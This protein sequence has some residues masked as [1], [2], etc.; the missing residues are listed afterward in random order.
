M[1]VAVLKYKWFWYWFITFSFPIISRHCLSFNKSEKEDFRKMHVFSSWF[2]PNIKNVFIISRHSD[3]H[4][5]CNVDTILGAFAVHKFS[6][7]V[8]GTF[9]CNWTRRNALLIRQLSTTSFKRV[10]YIKGCRRSRPVTVQLMAIHSR[11]FFLTSSFLLSHFFPLYFHPF[12][13]SF[14]LL[15]T[16]SF[17]FTFRSVLSLL[18]FFHSFYFYC[19]P[20]V[21]PFFLVGSSKSAYWLGLRLNNR[22]FMIRFQARARCGLF[23]NTLRSTHPRNQGQCTGLL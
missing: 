5:M 10:V 18:F 7:F 3:F 16:I 17:Y 12:S 19:A 14:S 20:F 11:F 4:F 2:R 22:G 15:F 6:N 8:A 9:L 1:V 13:F 21:F 23:S